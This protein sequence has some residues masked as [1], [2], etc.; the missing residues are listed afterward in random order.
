[1]TMRFG[2]VS[3]SNEPA[4][5]INEL[6]FRVAEVLMVLDGR[7]SDARR[8]FFFWAVDLKLR[9]EKTASGRCQNLLEEGMTDTANFGSDSNRCDEK[10]IEI[11][12]TLLLLA[13]VQF[14]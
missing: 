4:L 3:V 1:M 2:T 14:S 8:D 12:H 13:T 6:A 10:S 5:R 11:S 7:R 9:K